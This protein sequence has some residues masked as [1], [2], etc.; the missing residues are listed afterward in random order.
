MTE[1][2]AEP[3]VLVLCYSQGGTTLGLCKKLAA[4]EGYEL[5]EIK[6]VKPISKIGAFF[7]IPAIA[8]GKGVAVQDIAANWNAYEKVV[9]AGPIW[10]GN[11]TPVLRGFFSQYPVKGKTVVGLLTCMGGAGASTG[12]LRDM[13]SLGG[14][15]CEDVIIIS[16]KDPAGKSLIEG[17]AP[18][19]LEKLTA[20]R[21]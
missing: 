13:I 1:T 15:K 3:K 19:T 8:A 5:E 21:I 17:N 4:A 12:Q 18:V 9:I 14:G 6:P 10:A 20:A 16:G 7:K 11:P 2:V